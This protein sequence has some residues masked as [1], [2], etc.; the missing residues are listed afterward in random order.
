VSQP[1]FMTP[2]AGPLRG[3][4]ERRSATVVVWLAHQP[5]LLPPV[6][7]GVVFIAGLVLPGVAGA[8]VLLV[9]A[10]VMGLISY[11]SWPSVPSGLRSM[12][13]LIL[14]LVVAFAVFKLR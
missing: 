1:P 7:I 3:S 14:A 4:L 12:R 5:R 13:L 11:L 10:A 9:V 8:A 6:V 2:G